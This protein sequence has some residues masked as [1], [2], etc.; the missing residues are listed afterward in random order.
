MN[1]SND[2][3]SMINTKTPIKNTR[4]ST[5]CEEDSTAKSSTQKN[6]NNK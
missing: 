5:M 6:I 3:P 1:I 2:T 4:L